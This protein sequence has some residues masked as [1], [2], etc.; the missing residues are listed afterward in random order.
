MSGII[1]KMLF[2][3]LTPIEA[4]D[5]ELHSPLQS[6]DT[7]GK[8]SRAA[9]QT[10]QVMAQ[11]SVVTFYRISIGLAIRNFMAT[12][13]IPEVIISIKSIAMILFRFDS[14]VYHLLDNLLGAFPD[15][16]VAQKI[17]RSSIYE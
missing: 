2:H 3:K 6:F 4:E 9:C 1:G 5:K 10:S 14:F 7:P 12:V 17:A 8:T 13:V 16:F 15:D 11:F